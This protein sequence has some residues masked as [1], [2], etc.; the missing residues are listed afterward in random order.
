MTDL[1]CPVIHGGLSINLKTNGEIR[2]N[3]CCLRS[4]FNFSDNLKT[5]LFSSPSLESLRQF[6]KSN[7][8]AAGCDTCRL[9]EQTQYQSFRTGMTSLL[10]KTPPLHG[11][12][13][14][15]LMF[16]INCN[17][18]C[19]ICG[20]ESS[21]LWMKH[22]KE[23]N[24]NN[25]RNTPYRSRAEE[26]IKILSN[27]DF[28]DLKMVV[29]CGGETLLGTS[30]WKV[31]EYIA[32]RNSNITL[33]FQ[34]NGTQPILQKYY[35]LIEKFD[36]VKLH[37]SLDGTKDKF[38]YQRWPAEWNQVT[39]NILE[40]KE[41]APVNTMFLVEETLSVMNILYQNELDSWLKK[42]FFENRLG[43]EITH[44][45]HLAYKEFNLENITEEYYQ[46]LKKRNLSS[47]VSKNWKE[48]PKEIEFL[49]TKIKT[50]DKIRN[51]N[52]AKTFPEV[53][54]CYARYL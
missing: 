24:I 3:H 6:N 51:Q 43:D 19:R 47:L 45:K 8:W 2:Y 42:Y 15:D 7:N 37:I 12:T 10:G 22:L 52:F 40:I 16:D 38:N 25:T 17:L 1:Y 14:L 18:A 20:P 44:T 41:T 32:S 46:L 36:L 5:D 35:E 39:E 21:S 33:S 4:D 29:F 31:A 53:A 13:R 49:V 34:T 26:M 27:I 11:P 23:H 28:T 50:F 9:N 48:N 30:Y 54:E